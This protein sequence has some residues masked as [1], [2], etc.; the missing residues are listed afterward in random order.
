M[1]PPKIQTFDVS[2]GVNVDNKGLRREVT[3]F[4]RTPFG[5]YMSRAVVGRAS[6]SWLESWLLPDLG[7]VVSDW[8]WKPGHEREQDF[9]L[10]VARIEPGDPTWRT[11]DL[12]LDVIVKTGAWSEVLDVDEFVQATAHGLLDPDTAEWGLHRCVET[13]AALATHGHDLGAWL[14]THGIALTW[15]GE[16]A[17]RAG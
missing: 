17:A 14:A 1:H 9:Y 10:D 12:Y 4:R 2:T 11:T 13:M 6:A 7:I 15:K 3:E 5:L 16:G 8:T